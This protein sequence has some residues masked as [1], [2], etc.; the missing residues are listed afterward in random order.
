M[1]HYEYKCIHK[2]PQ[3]VTTL[4]SRKKILIDLIT[5]DVKNF[6]FFVHSVQQTSTWVLKTKI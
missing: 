4:N 5:K 3:F 1:E 6:Q 2:L